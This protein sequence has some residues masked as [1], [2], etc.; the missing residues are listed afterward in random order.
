LAARCEFYGFDPH[1]RAQYVQQWSGRSRRALAVTTLKPATTASVGC[2]CNSGPINMR[3]PSGAIQPRRPHTT[4]RFCP[5]RVSSTI[6]V[7]SGN[8]PGQLCERPQEYRAKLY[9]AGYLS[10]RRRYSRAEPAGELHLRQE[11]E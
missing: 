7:A 8:I 10:L 3:C 6:Q 1:A 4:P 5:D 2:T 11:S 9:D